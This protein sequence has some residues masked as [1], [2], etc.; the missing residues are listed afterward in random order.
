MSG[1]DEST[2]QKDSLAIEATNLVYALC[3]EDS[4]S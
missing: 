2:D 1:N 4:F 3:D